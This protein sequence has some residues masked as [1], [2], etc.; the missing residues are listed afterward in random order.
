MLISARRIATS[1]THDAL[2][3]QLIDKVALFSKLKT[4]VEEIKCG[5]CDT[6]GFLVVN[7]AA[8]PKGNNDIGGDV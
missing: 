7:A 1:T 8:L 6:S 4:T 2:G 3:T 5:T